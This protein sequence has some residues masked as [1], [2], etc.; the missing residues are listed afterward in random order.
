MKKSLSRSQGQVEKVR[1]DYSMQH[2]KNESCGGV[3]IKHNNLY[4]EKM[5]GSLS[6]LVW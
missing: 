5:E 1:G 4:N 3:C 6:P 2:N